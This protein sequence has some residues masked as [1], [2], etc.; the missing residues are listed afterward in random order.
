MWFPA[1]VWEK[2]LCCLSV[3]ERW[4]LLQ[5]KP[6][7]IWS[8]RSQ[9]WNRLPLRTEKSLLV[10]VAEILKPT[11]ARK[12][13]VLS[14]V[15]LSRSTCFL[16]FAVAFPNPSTSGSQ[17]RAERPD[18]GTLALDSL[19]QPQ[20]GFDDKILCLWP[21][22]ASP[23][24]IQSGHASICL[25]DYVQSVTTLPVPIAL[26][27]LF[28]PLCLSQAPTCGPGSA[29]MFP[30]SHPGFRIDFHPLHWAPCWGVSHHECCVPQLTSNAV[31]S[32]V[33]A[34]LERLS[35]S[36]PPEDYLRQGQALPMSAWL[37]ERLCA[38]RSSDESVRVPHTVLLFL[39]DVL[40]VVKMQLQG[41]R[42]P[43]ID[44]I[45]SSLPE[46]MAM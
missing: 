17:R 16:F 26:L 36:Y 2:R 13:F 42:K 11:A 10:L 32:G 31:L 43:Q 27:Q 18:R 35:P 3:Q 19:I 29:P 23:R 8:L 24:G 12:G 6:A 39:N 7:R 41:F 44:P 34:Y 9:K 40:S 22:A 45:R 30:R 37:C 21:T 15:F 20:P 14:W 28:L 46:T 1:T 5:L 38:L 25:R 4:A 33:P